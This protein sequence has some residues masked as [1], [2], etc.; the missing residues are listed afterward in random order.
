MNSFALLQDDVEDDGATVAVESQPPVPESSVSS[1]GSK[2]VP[3]TTAS[4]SKNEASENTDKPTTETGE[5]EKNTDANGDKEGGEG[6]SKEDDTPKER[7]LT[8]EE[9]L[10][11]KA[12]MASAMGSLNI[13]GMRQA[14]DGKGAFAKM[15]VLKKKVD[16]KEVMTGVAVKEIQESKDPKDSTHTAVA[17]NA[18]MQKFFQRDPTE[19]RPAFRGRGRGEFRGRGRGGDRGRFERGRGG[20]RGD[21]GGRG[22]DRGDRGR[23]GMGERGR[24]RGRPFRGDGG[25]RGS[26]DNKHFQPKN[27]VVGAP[28]VDDIS[29]FPSL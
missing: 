26:N 19:R 2:P 9:Y 24:G 13:R 1:L 4:T 23:G 3:S 11:Q 25:F 15:S 8:L 21:R 7:D 20:D 10:E 17:R 14:N 28:N 5:D 6:S 29:A 18:E 16:A 27:S 22:G 12:A